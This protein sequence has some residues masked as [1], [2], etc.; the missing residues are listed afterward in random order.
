MVIKARI[1][2]SVL[3]VTILLCSCQTKEQETMELREENNVK[4]EQ[5]ADAFFT[6]KQVKERLAVSQTK[7]PAWSKNSVIYEVNVRQYTP[8][9]TFK[10]FEAHLPRLKDLGVDILW[11]MPIHPISEKERKGTLGS[12]YAVQDYKAINPEF[13]TL[14]DFKALVETAHDMGFKI[15]LDI[16]A[17]HTGWDNDWINNY[18]WYTT[19][20]EGEIVSP[21]GQGTTWPDVAE[22]NYDNH[23]MR[24]E[25]IEVMKFWIEEIGVDGYRADYANGV[26]VD[27]WE[28]VRKELD[29]IKE[30]YMLAEDNKVYELL[31][32]A[33][34]SNYGWDLTHIM[35][36]IAHGKQSAK[37]IERYIARIEKLYPQGTYPMHFT[38]NHDINSWEGTTED[39]LGEAAEI[40]TVLTFTLPGIP[41]IYSGQEA[42]LDKQLLFFEKDEINW[43]DLSMQQFYEQLVRLKKENEALW[44]GDYGGDISF[45]ETADEHVLAFTRKKADNEVIVVMNLSPDVKVAHVNIGKLAGEY[46]MYF[47]DEKVQL[48]G[49]EKFNLNPWE[50]HVFIK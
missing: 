1:V 6:G 44:N 9:G 25:M 26:P 37:A 16:V 50:Y 48:N 35:N 38:T 23:E 17:N 46:K 2:F 39:L 27:F 45:L 32:H 28:A 3:L 40:M 20:S 8:E 42:G 49:D 30:V 29:E 21:S 12:Y 47:N 15:L 41:L 4:N 14:D 34:N 43:D 22:L 33:F 18:G 13:G 7:V 10:A 5:S 31:E 11:F 24:A 19:N 36:E